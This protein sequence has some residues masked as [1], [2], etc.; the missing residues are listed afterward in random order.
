MSEQQLNKERFRTAYERIAEL[1]RYHLSPDSEIN[2]MPSLVPEPFEACWAAEC[3]R[4][5]WKPK[6]LRF[7]LLA[8]SHVYTDDNDL[9]AQ[10]QAE[11]LPI[12]AQG[13]P[14]QFVRLIYCLAYGDSSLLTH[15]LQQPNKGTPEFWKLFAACVLMRPI[16]SF[17]SVE[18]KVK[19]LLALQSRGVWLADAS[20]H[21]CMNPRFLYNS[22][23]RDKRRNIELFP[24]LYR[25][26]LAASWDY[27][28]STLD[29]AESIWVVGKLVRDNLHDSTLDKSRWIYQP[30]CRMKPQ[31][32]EF[33]TRQLERL[34]AELSV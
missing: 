34:I 21:A 32:I 6:N 20:I 13:A 26:V 23:V 18:T 27:V 29:D 3:H 19:I 4:Q 1:Y 7:A 12:E 25:D 11:L 9:S 10:V 2:P 5:Y 16:P 8:E 22:I 15:F 30:G 31:Q 24:R 14:H 33:Q 17:F 28:K